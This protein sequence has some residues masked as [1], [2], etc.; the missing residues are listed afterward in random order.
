MSTAPR[1]DPWGA[2]PYLVVPPAAR[3]GP[4]HA[5]IAVSLVN[6]CPLVTHGLSSM[7]RPYADRL[8]LVA[9][10]TPVDI[11]LYDA[12]QGPSAGYADVDAV[13]ADPSSGK[14]VVYA[15]NL[16][17]PRVEDLLAQ[18]FAG[19]VDQRATAEELVDAVERVAHG[20]HGVRH[21]A[22]AEGTD[23]TAGQW[24]G[25]Q[26]GLSRREAEVVCLIAQGVTNQDICDRLYLSANTVKTYIRSAYHKLGV[27]RR[28]E[29]VRWGVE[30]GLTA[31]APLG[32]P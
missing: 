23:P 17:A 29:A 5:V 9:P 7:L 11:T 2:H 12:A 16:P 30:H 20:E 4:G 31:A 13:L 32:V 15:R 18:G 27:T 22:D 26:H 8:Q 1:L 10:G 14:V 21:Q 25:Q 3:P 6:D 28:A 19:Y 24:P